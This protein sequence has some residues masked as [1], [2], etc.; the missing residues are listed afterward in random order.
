[1]NPNGIGGGRADWIDLAQD[2]VQ[3]K[4]LVK[5]TI[6][7]CAQQKEQNSSL[8]TPLLDSQQASYSMKSISELSKLPNKV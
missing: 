7:V 3:W 5:M 8:A 2:R 4:V 1:M 6:I